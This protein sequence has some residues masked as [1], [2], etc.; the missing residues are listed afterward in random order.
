MTDIGFMT[1]A[2]R[3]FRRLQ[4]LAERA[5]AQVDDEGF[6]RVRGEDGNSPAVLVKH[7][8]GN[9]RSR[10]RDFLTSDGEKPDR[11]RDT[12]F[13]LDEADDRAALMARWRDAW[14][15]LHDALD[16][17]DDGDLERTVTIRG[18]PHTVLQAVSRQ[19][20]HYAYHVG[21]IVLL[22]RLEAGAA[23]QSLSVPRG[24]SQAFNAAPKRYLDGEG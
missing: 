16:P 7:V 15:I 13:E 9:L 22:A 2:V 3:E 6:F 11:R 12:E 4:D 14:A 5:L 24:R 17:L 1:G 8:A 20:T 21:Q 18:E 23:W 10:W 19:L